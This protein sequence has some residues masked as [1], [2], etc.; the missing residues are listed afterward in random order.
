MQNKV[1]IVKY[2]QRKIFTYEFRPLLPLREPIKPV[3]HRKQT[4]AANSLISTGYKLGVKSELNDMYVRQI[5]GVE[6]ICVYL[7]IH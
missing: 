4:T 7:L 5:N 1:G 3:S 6:D 2:V